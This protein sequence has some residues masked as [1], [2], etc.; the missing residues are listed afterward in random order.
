MRRLLTAARKRRIIGVFAMLGIASTLWFAYVV[1]TPEDIDSPPGRL[2]GGPGLQ[3][4]ELGIALAA[5][6]NSPVTSGNRVDLLVN[7][8]EIFPAMLDA[9]RGAKD[10]VHLL[11]YVYW[12]GPIADD[13]A[14]ELAAA[15]RRGVKV[16]LLLDAFGGRKI[17]E[18]WLQ[19]MRRDGVDVAWFRPLHWYTL[20]RYDNRTHR[21][22]L[23]VDGRIGF[24]GG[25]GIAAEWMGDAQDPD[26]WRDDH[27]R[28][29]G[30]AV[31]A[32][33]G[34]F[35]EN[36]REAIGEVLAG[37][38]IFPVQEAA[39]DARVIGIN[40]AP[41]ES[42]QGVPLAYWML[43][44]SARRRLLIATPYFVPDADLQHDVV[45]A[46]RRGVEVTLLVPGRHQDS[47]LV[48]YASR[49]YYR[50]LLE[51]G[52]RIHEYQPTLM[53]SKVMV[54]D[55]DW[56][57]IGS[58][59]FDSRSLEFNYENA[60]AVRDRALA[61][62]LAESTAEDLR[63]ARPITLEEVD[64]WSAFERARN[65]LALLLREQL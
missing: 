23:V 27:F 49:T 58:P 26:H 57:L 62:R 40:T 30:P 22:V 42:F 12:T 50:A 6:L 7:G 20:R 16:R 43:I 65:A 60:L 34:A 37:D 5:H 59:N 63:N 29:R 18:R 48:R 36:W 32:L 19:R 17:D 45:A 39:G 47:K 10:S 52:V 51:A 54:V 3:G 15:A 4:R 55:D 13:F 31:T 56:S 44:N 61:A 38:R 21:K 35:A 11:T 53:H 1:A 46:A 9:I 64:D 2:S 33:Q 14:R 24:T 28:V 25:V 8:D 41:G